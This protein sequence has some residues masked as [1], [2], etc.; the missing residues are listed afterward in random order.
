MGVFVSKNHATKLWAPETETT[1]HSLSGT[2]YIFSI[3]VCWMQKHK[4]LSEQ[5]ISS[6]NFRVMWW[7]VLLT[8]ACRSVFH[9]C[10]FEANQIT[11]CSLA[12]CQAF[13]TG[14]SLTHRLH[15]RGICSFPW[16]R[17]FFLAELTGACFST[18]PQ[19]SSFGSISESLRHSPIPY[20]Q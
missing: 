15:P 9:N 6:L 4:R 12:T 2:Q 13:D 5:M 14:S 20:I 3:N 19:V 11:K 16:E 10:Q 7:G 18:H 1:C 17:N 8:A